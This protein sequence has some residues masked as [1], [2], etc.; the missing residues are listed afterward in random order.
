MPRADLR[1]TYIDGPTA[2]L[3]VAGLRFLTDPTF[4]PAGTAYP[5]AAYTLRKTRS[6][7]MGPQ[8]VGDLAGV[9]LSHDHHFDNLDHLGRALLAQVPAIYT[10]VAGAERLGRNAIGLAPWQSVTCATPD[11]R[12]L[13]ITATPARHGPAGGDR[14]PVVGFVLEPAAG[15]GAPVYVSGDTG[16]YDEVA[17]VGRRVPVAVALLNLGA[18]KVA[19]AGPAP[20]TF[21]AAEAVALADAWPQA[22][23]VPLHFEGWEHFTEGRRE[24]DA[25]FRAAG[26]SDRLHWLEPGVPTTFPQPAA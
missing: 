13:R 1:I 3:E 5:T 21:T 9:L 12:A 10:T 17:E 25:A 20:L 15:A 11:G 7:A 24:V 16:W 14:G 19:V 4:D 26:L 2:I 8:A 22:R 23:I 18:A 6:P